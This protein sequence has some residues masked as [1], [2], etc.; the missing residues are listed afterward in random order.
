MADR[1]RASPRRA[2]AP[3]RRPAA[4]GQARARQDDHA[5]GRQNPPGEPRRS[6][7]NDR[8]LRFCRRP[9]TPALRPDHRQRAAQP[10]DDGAMASAR[11]GAGDQRVQFPGRGLGVECRAGAGLR[12]SCDLEAERKD[13]A[14]R[15]A[16]DAAGAPRVA[17]LRRCAGWACAI[18]AGRARGRSAFGRRSAH[19]FGLGDRVDGDGP[20]GGPARGRTLRTRAARARRQ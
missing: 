8:Y 3:A 14:L 18:G 1:A 19:C 17:W 13:P 5:R 15:R 6:P 11:A 9:V 2:R 16:G 10:P 20:G 7:G 4:R 12:Q